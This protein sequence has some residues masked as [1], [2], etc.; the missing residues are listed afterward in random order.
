VK[1]LAAGAAP[2]VLAVAVYFLFVAFTRSPDDE[3]G[4]TGGSTTLASTT[5]TTTVGSAPGEGAW[6]LLPAQTVVEVHA[7]HL[8]TTT[9]TTAP[10][11]PPSPP[12]PRLPQ[13]SQ[14]GGTVWDRLAECES[15]GDWSANTGN[16]HS[17]GLQW[18]HDTWVRAGGLAHAPTAWQATREQEIVVAEAWLARTSW[19][20]WPACSRRLGLR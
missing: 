2:F 10:P 19:A 15:G 18:L 9:T 13:P 20:Q 6:S 16:G 11:P 3:A 1:R 12:A 8:S 14:G 4:D 7:W 5:S 17:G